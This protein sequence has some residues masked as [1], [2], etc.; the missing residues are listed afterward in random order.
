MEEDKEKHI[1]EFI[2]SYSKTL[3]ESER[4]EILNNYHL[5]TRKSAKG[6]SDVEHNLDM[7][8]KRK[9]KH[10]FWINKHH[11]GILFAPLIVLVLFTISYISYFPHLSKGIFL[12]VIG[13]L[14]LLFML[15]KRIVKDATEKVSNY[16]NYIRQAA[17]KELRERKKGSSSQMKSLSSKKTKKA[18]R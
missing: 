11:I 15:T 2:E 7:V 14:F 17:K 3:S 16:Q 4:I 13:F 12:T 5:Y 6:I 9:F 18:R 10:L 1:E 8:A